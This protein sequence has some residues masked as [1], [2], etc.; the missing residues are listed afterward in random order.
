[1]LDHVIL[2]SLILGNI[3]LFWNGN[4][5]L[6]LFYLP[7]PPIS[8]VTFPPFSYKNPNITRIK[9]KILWKPMAYNNTAV[10]TFDKNQV[11]KCFTWLMALVVVL[12]GRRRR[13]MK[14]VMYQMLLAELS[15]MI[16]MRA[17]YR[18]QWLFD[19]RASVIKSWL[20]LW[21]YIV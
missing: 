20:A 13:E 7:H 6:N 21:P 12:G 16:K 11:I 1:M 8:C 17:P 3:I 4:L 19:S 2:N 15:I 5:F 10:L 18:C 9:F 14:G